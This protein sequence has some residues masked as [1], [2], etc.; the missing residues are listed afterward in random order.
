[1]EELMARDNDN[2]DVDGHKHRTSTFSTPSDPYYSILMKSIIGRREEY[3]IF[4]IHD[5]SKFL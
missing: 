3:H 5:M 2:Q 4:G 1:M